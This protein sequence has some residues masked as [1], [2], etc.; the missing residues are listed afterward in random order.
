VLESAF[1]MVPKAT[2]HPGLLHLHV[3]LMEMSPYPERALWS[4]DRLVTRLKAKTK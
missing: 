2:N 3:H 4:G 1:R